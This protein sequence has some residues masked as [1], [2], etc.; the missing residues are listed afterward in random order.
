[1]KKIIYHLR[2]QP[3]Y[4]R[5]KILH[6]LTILATVILLI[7]W[8]YSLGKNLTNQDTQVKVKEDL[9]PFSVLKNNLMS[10]W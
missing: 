8:V 10:L 2:K 5:I 7:L 1:M 6:V 9:K 4:I 3:E